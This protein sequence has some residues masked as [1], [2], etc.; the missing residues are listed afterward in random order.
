MT[1]ILY[2]LIHVHVSFR[3]GLVDEVVKRYVSPRTSDTSTNTEKKKGKEISL[4]E[5]VWF[6]QKT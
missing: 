5:T 1:E 2:T 6:C 3:Q 4:N